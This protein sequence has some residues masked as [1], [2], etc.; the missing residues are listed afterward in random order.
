RAVGAGSSRWRA[1][2]A[3]RSRPAWPASSSIVSFFWGGFSWG[4]RLVFGGR[5]GRAV[6]GVLLAQEPLE[7]VEPAGPEALVE[8]Q[9]VVGAGERPRVEPA[10][11]R[12]P[13]HLAPDEPGVLERLDVLRRRRQRNRERLGELG[14]RPL[15]AG[16]FPKHPPPCGVA[17]GV[18]DGVERRRL[19]F[20]HAV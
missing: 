19:K 10:P 4:V 6:A 16:E 7:N 13:A 15:A 20:N 1:R 3:R 8:A 5:D 11:V 12:A 18:E 14:H 9:P 2:S 17:E